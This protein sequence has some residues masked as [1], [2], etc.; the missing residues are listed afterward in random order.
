M[1]PQTEQPEFINPENPI[2]KPIQTMA[3]EFPA[4]NEGFSSVTI[5]WGTKDIDREGETKWDPDFIG[6]LIWDESFNMAHEDSQ[7]FLKKMC[8][9]LSVQDF[10]M[11]DENTFKCW[12]W[13][14]EEFVT[15][16]VADSNPDATAK[17]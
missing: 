3:D 9:D 8:N 10:T 4:D 6:D 5:F 1:G 14:F 15:R 11:N 17:K 16:T 13:A 12:I 2:W 7:V